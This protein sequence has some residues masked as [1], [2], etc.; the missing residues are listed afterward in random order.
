[1][2]FNDRSLSNIITLVFD[3]IIEYDYNDIWYNYQ[4]IIIIFNMDNMIIII[5]NIDI[6]YDYNEI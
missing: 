4:T 2:R 3:A 1:M 5:F 6:K